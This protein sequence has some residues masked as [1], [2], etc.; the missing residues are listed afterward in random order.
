MARDHALRCVH[1]TLAR[2]CDTARP[3][4]QHIGHRLRVAAAQAQNEGQKFMLAARADDADRA[5]IEQREPVAR[6]AQ[7]IAG[8]RIAVKAAVDQHHVQHRLRPQIGHAVRIDAGL[9]Q[10]FRIARGDPVDIVHHQ[11]VF[12]GPLPMDARQHDRVL[13]REIGAQKIRIAPLTRKIQFVQQIAGQLID[14][15]HGVEPAQ[16]GAGFLGQ[17]DRLPDQ[18][19][20]GFDDGANA[21][22]A[23]L[24]HHLLPVMQLG[25]V[26]LCHGRGG[27]RL[28]VEPC[29]GGLHRFAKAGLHL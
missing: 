17:P 12:A 21:G 4:R 19:K 23:D 2:H 24:E 25:P 26:N 13:I 1:D 8:M 28:P 10:T 7:Q 16:L 14:H 3:D 15:R 5:E 22:A 11:Q 9:A 27:Q 6:Q 20:I 18:A 29:K